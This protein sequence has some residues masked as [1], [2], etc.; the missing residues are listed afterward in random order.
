MNKFENMPDDARVWV[1]AANKR[2]NESL[3]SEILDKTNE[4]IK[5]WTNHEKN[6]TALAEILNNT[7]LVIMVDETNLMMG[8]CGID[9]SL[10]FVR[11]LDAE[12]GL[13]FM[14][15][16]AVQL[17]D[18][19]SVIS[20]SKDEAIQWFEQGKIQENSICY[21]NTVHSKKELTNNWAIAF[22]NSWVYK[23]AIQ[24]SN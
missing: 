20:L 16:H 5:G 1:Y 3:Q 19:E 13:G 9:K 22:K 14:N 11:T 18:G 21:N 7:F 15:R 4:F 8:G 10:T 17:A 24:V 12:Y 23:S 6:V 2:I